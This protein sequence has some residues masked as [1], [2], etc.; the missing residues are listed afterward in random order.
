MRVFT[1]PSHMPGDGRRVNER[2]TSLPTAPMA[3]VSSSSSG[4]HSPVNGRTSPTRRACVR[5]YV[6]LLPWLVDV[7]RAIV[8]WQGRGTLRQT[9]RVGSAAI[10]L[11]EGMTA[12]LGS[13]G[14]LRTFGRLP[15]THRTPPQKAPR[16]SCGHGASKS[17][18]DSACSSVCQLAIQVVLQA[19]ERSAN[20]RLKSSFT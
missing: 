16:S 20:V 12:D 15:T 2:L 4:S 19:R 6:H 11:M 3:T 7:A 9:F 17:A 8:C 18:P 1:S 14:Y 13:D 10:S 5:V